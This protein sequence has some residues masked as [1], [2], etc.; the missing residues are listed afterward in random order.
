[1]NQNFVNNNKLGVTALGKCEHSSEPVHTTLVTVD[2]YAWH[3]SAK[4]I[5][6][7]PNVT[8]RS[9]RLSKELQQLQLQVQ[10]PA[11]FVLSAMEKIWVRDELED[12]SCR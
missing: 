1:M 6:T 11:D 4:R 2:H 8:E 9:A 10:Q 7:H 12:D 5:G 3:G